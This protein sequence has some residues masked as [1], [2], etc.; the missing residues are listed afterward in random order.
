MGTGTEGPGSTP[1][2]SLEAS[3]LSFDS[4]VSSGTTPRGAGRAEPVGPDAEP[5]EDPTESSLLLG[6][7]E[8]PPQWG[9]FPA[10]GVLS[11]YAFLHNFKPSEPFLVSFLVHEKG[12]PEPVV[13]DQI[14]AVWIYAHAPALLVTGLLSELI[15]CKPV[16][17]GG[18]VAGALTVALTLFGEA[19]ELMQLSQVTVATS[20]ACYTSFWA[21]VF[22]SVTPTQYQASAHVTKSAALAAVCSSALLGQMLSERVPLRGLFWVS[23]VMQ[24]CAVA[25]AALLPSGK[26]Q[27]GADS[28]SQEGDRAGASVVA[29][30]AGTLLEVGRDVW[31]ALAVLDVAAWIVW[32]IAASS[33]HQLVITFWQNLA[34]RG[35]S[36]CNRA[37][38]GYV[39]AAAYFSAGLVTMGSARLPF[40]RISRFFL[41]ISLAL[42]GALVIAMASGGLARL[43]V[44]LVAAQILYELGSAVGITQIAGDVTDA[45]ATRFSH[46]V[47]RG[48]GVVTEPRLPALFSFHNVVSVGLE[49][50]MQLTMQ[51]G[52]RMGIAARFTAM[53]V[54]LCCAA[55]VLGVWLSVKTVQQK[56]MPAHL[57]DAFSAAAYRVKEFFSSV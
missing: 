24:W 2:V 17:L 10:L 49:S 29:A 28:R 23:L 46:A 54:L 18:A 30:F 11:L 42:L 55:A 43:Y 12:F 6:T 22:Y 7:N 8:P 37:A 35:S 48:A 44:A 27:A 26:R 41:L 53:G 20:F 34:C 47:H 19:L 36:G 56:R 13:R 39:L 57:E 52:L 31:K 51:K 14:F 5:A 38:N 45:A 33:V 4:I 21:L 9:R 32:L 40:R 1:R 25:C 15:G 3:R 50:A 16:V